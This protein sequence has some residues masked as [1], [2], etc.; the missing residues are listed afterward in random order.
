MLE[1]KF[2]L[3]FICGCP[4]KSHVPIGGTLRK[5]LNHGDVILISRLVSDRFIAKS[6]IMWSLLKEVGL[7]G[8]GLDGS[9][10]LSLPFVSLCFFLQCYELFPLCSAS[11]PWSQSFKDQSVYK[12]V[13]QNKTFFLKVGCI[14][15]CLWV[16]SMSLW[17]C[18]SSPAVSLWKQKS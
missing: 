4:P 9:V 6:G 1:I 16:M 12:F 10:S 5:W 17:Y 3:G 11:L 2:L 18:N 14:G 8:H 13:S 7:C 15:Y